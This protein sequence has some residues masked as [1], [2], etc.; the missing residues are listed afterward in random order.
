[1]VFRHF[2]AGFLRFRA[3]A[4]GRESFVDKKE[5]RKKLQNVVQTTETVPASPYNKNTVKELVITKA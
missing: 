3:S 4:H 1:V 5:M 2:P